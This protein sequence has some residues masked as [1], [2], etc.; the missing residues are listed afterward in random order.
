ML[1]PSKPVLLVGTRS[2]LRK[3][4]EVIQKLWETKQRP[5]A[6]TEGMEV[7]EKIRAVIYLECCVS[8]NSG[9]KRIYEEA[10]KAALRGRRLCT[11][12]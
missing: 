1:L 3:C 5:V 2:D 7:L 8:K 12:W 10:A 6:W 4:E 11:I 9:I